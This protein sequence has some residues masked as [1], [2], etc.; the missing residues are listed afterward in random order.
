M[1]FRRTASR[2][3]PPIWILLL[4]FVT[5]E[6]TVGVEVV[7]S[8]S[9][10]YLV[11]NVSNGGLILIRNT[12]H[13]FHVN[14][15]SSPFWIKTAMSTGTSNAY[16]NGVTNNGV[17]SGILTFVVPR[18]APSTL[19]YASQTYAAMAGTITVADGRFE[20]S[21]LSFHFFLLAVLEFLAPSPGVLQIFSA[22]F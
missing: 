3:L 12:T 13:Q 17:T 14:A 9:S 7:A 15:P 1:G 20:I 4:L 10:A 2:I 8:G 18:A 19:Y 11:D 5:F 22:S 21:F 6:H 16:T